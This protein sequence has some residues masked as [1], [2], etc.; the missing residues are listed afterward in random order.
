M[1]SC[2]I[3]IQFEPNHHPKKGRYC[4][5]MVDDPQ[6]GLLYFYDCNGDFVSWS[7]TGAQP[8]SP[9]EPPV[10]EFTISLPLTNPTE[11]VFLAWTA[12]EQ[13]TAIRFLA[14]RQGG[15]GAT[16]NVRKNGI[17]LLDTDLSLATAGAW[18]EGAPLKETSFA[19]GDTLEFVVTAVEGDIQSITFSMEFEKNV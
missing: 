2:G 4:N 14:L 19:P 10:E 12:D 5:A 8:D 7:K 11:G 9:G 1:S 3:K 6:N 18:L 16:V 13:S 17:L 15:I